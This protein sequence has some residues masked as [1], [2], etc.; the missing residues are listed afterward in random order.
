MNILV[1]EDS[2]TF[3]LILGGLLKKLGHEMTAV[4]SGLEAWNLFQKQ[5][6]PV[7]I[8]DWQMPEIDGMV[9]MSLVRA[10]PHDKYTYVIMIASRGGK[11]S[12][13]EAMK[14]GADDFIAKPPDEEQLAARL[15]VAERIVG[16]QNHVRRLEAVMSVCSYCKRVR[17]AGNQWV[18]MEEYIAR[19][20]GTTPSHTICPPCF[21]T[22]VKPELDRLGVQMD[23]SKVW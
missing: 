9:L 18:D 15:L 4:E 16:V 3:R 17:E 8:T 22:K 21:R 5:Y 10:K 11:E 12:Y 20:L 19:H 6:F 7:L 23:E 13:L 14:A 2:S 1:A